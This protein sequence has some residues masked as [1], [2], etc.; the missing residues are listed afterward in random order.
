MALE[1]KSEI[2][3]SECETP[4]HRWFDCVKKLTAMPKKICAL[5]SMTA[6]EIFGEL[7]AVEIDVILARQAEG[8]VAEIFPSWSL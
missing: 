8:P 6:R 1:R 7:A 4:T 3:R 2:S 5:E